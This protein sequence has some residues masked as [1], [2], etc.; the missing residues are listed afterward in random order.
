MS[1]L[2]QKLTQNRRAI[3]DLAGAHG[4][5]N[6]RVFGSVARGTDS[7]ASDVDLLVDLPAGMS[8]FT[9]ARLERD[10]AEV[11]GTKVDVVPANTLRGHLAGHVIAEAVPL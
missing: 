5:R 11:I 9:L 2:G 8:L 7:P 6:V 4:I 1:A 3:L 10:L